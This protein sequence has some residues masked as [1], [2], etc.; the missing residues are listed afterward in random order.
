MMEI[1]R[2]SFAQYLEWQRRCA[3]TRSD[4]FELLGATHERA[5]AEQ[6][7]AYR[8]VLRRAL[9]GAAAETVGSWLDTLETL[10]CGRETSRRWAPAHAHRAKS[11]YSYRPAEGTPLDALVRRDPFHDVFPF[12]DGEALSMLVTTDAGP[13]SQSTELRDTIWHRILHGPQRSRYLFLHEIIVGHYLHALHGDERPLRRSDLRSGAR[14][15]VLPAYFV[16]RIAAYLGVGCEDLAGLHFATNEEIE[17]AL[18]RPIRDLMLL[19]AHAYFWAEMLVLYVWRRRNG[20]IIE[21]VIQYLG[22]P[23]LEALERDRGARVDDGAFTATEGPLG[24]LY[25]GAT[26][27]QEAN[28]ADLV[29]ALVRLSEMALA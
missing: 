4:Y 15:E 18:P 6:L 26:P 5:M 17:H 23:I 8:E 16:R 21:N 19:C 29:R 11:V 24:S 20:L 3:P 10:V 13:L 27:I 7:R 12:Y 14:Y 28:E 9:T 22:L 2:T 1:D 25:H